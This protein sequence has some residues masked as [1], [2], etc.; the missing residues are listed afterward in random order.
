MRNPPDEASDTPLDY[1]RSPIFDADPGPKSTKLRLLHFYQSDISP[2]A[3]TK[4]LSFPQNLQGFTLTHQDLMR[5]G[6]YENRQEVEVFVEAL[7][8]QKESLEILKLQGLKACIGGIRLYM[9]SCLQNLEIEVDLLFGRLLQGQESN[10]VAEGP[11]VDFDLENLLPPSLKQLTLR[12]RTIN[13]PVALHRLEALASFVEE[14]P[15]ML[16]NMRY[17]RL[18]EEML[19]DEIITISQEDIDAIQRR[20]LDVLDRLQVNGVDGEHKVQELSTEPWSP[21]LRELMSALGNG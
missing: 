2:Q 17:V 12:Y 21:S 18:I 6:Q 10:P 9:F 1:W 15:S 19:E 8:Q 4:L 3:L 16:P 7:R 5:S 20:R 13:N 11:E 14:K